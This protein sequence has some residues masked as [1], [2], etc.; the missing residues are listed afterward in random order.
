MEEAESIF[1]E[2]GTPE[3]VAVRPDDGIVPL[4]TGLTP[5][6]KDEFKKLLDTA[7]PLAERAAK[8]VGLARLKGTKTAGVGLRA[9]QEINALCG[10]NNEAS[11]QAAPMFQLPPGTDVSVTITKVVK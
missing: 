3:G 2:L 4:D 10:L 6:E 8:L 11:M 1:E 5:D 7:M 9:L